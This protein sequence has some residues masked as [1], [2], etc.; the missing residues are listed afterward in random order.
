LLVGIQ[1]VEKR[2][3]VG[4]SAALMAAPSCI[5]LVIFFSQSMDFFGQAKAIAQNIQHDRSQ[6]KPLRS[7]PFVN[8]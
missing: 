2:S 6:D 8:F 7:P 4:C 3:G 1:R 5:P